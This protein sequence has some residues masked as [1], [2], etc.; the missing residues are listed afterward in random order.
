MYPYYIYTA[1]VR[2][3]ILYISIYEFLVSIIYILYLYTYL[4][5]GCGDSERHLEDFESKGDEV[6][7][8]LKSIRSEAGEEWLFSFPFEVRSELESMEDEEAF[9]SS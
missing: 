9:A 8:R 3:C 1:V 4:F 5:G 7:R 2:I 6:L